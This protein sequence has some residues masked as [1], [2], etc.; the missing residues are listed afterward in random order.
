MRGSSIA[1]SA[2]DV[3]AR[4]LIFASEP[5]STCGNRLTLKP[6]A[7]QRDSRYEMISAFERDE[8]E[9]IATSSA[10]VS[11]TVMIRLS[12]LFV[13]APVKR[14]VNEP[15]KM[16]AEFSPGRKPGDQFDFDSIEPAKRGAEFRKPVMLELASVAPS[17]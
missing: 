10:S 8:T 3:W 7:S 4:R 13:I 9:S 2:V 6:A 5:S 12:S 14:P 1:V 16:A 15:S 17:G 11:S